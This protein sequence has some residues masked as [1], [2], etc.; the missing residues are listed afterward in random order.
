MSSLL[1]VL[2]VN[3]KFLSYFRTRL[4]G[5][6]IFELD[7]KLFFLLNEHILLRYLFSLGNKPFLERLDLLDH[8]ISFWVSAFKLSPPMNVEWLCKL[9]EQIFSLLLLLKVL[10]LKEVD[11]PL[12]I[13]DTC[14]LAL[15]SNEFSLQ[16][17]NFFPNV[18]DIIDFLL[19][20]NLSLL[21]SR[22]LNLDLLIEQSKLFVSFDKLCS[23]DISLINNH[24]VV[25]P[26]LLLL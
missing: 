12:K 20:V 10:F 7:V 8:F 1:Q 25:L 6:D 21:Q 18:Q 26:L 24:L 22:F 9:V 15:R 19:I 3:L 13:W 2:L 16:L 11:F 14:S 17:G 23:E 5:Q 4:L